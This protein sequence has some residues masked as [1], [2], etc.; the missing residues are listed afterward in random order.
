M[1]NLIGKRLNHQQNT[2]SGIINTPLLIL[3]VRMMCVIRVW[4]RIS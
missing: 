4:L 2:E 3:K 1:W